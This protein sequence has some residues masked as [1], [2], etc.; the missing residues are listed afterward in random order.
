MRLAVDA[1]TVLQRDITVVA[2]RVVLHQ[3]FDPLDV[4]II[5]FIYDSQRFRIVISRPAHYNCCPI[6]L[7]VRSLTV[8]AL[9]MMTTFSSVEINR[10]F[11]FLTPSAS[12]HLEF[13]VISLFFYIVP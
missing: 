8:L 7:V 13:D 10:V 2:V 4:D 6:G 1:N 5:I 3:F 11:V 12:R 9:S